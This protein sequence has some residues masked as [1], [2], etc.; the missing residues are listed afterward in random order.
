MN[1]YLLFEDKQSDK[2]GGVDKCQICVYLTIIFGT[3]LT[4]LLT[5]FL[6]LTPKV[7]NLVDIYFILVIFYISCILCFVCVFLCLV[8]YLVCSSFY[9][10]I[11]LCFDYFLCSC[12]LSFEEHHVGMEGEDAWTM[13]QEHHMRRQLA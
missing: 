13:A 5:L 12:C 9:K 4:C 6:I 1:Q 10:L 7:V 3:Y 2:L 8:F 11:V